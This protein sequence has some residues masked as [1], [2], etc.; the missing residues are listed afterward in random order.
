MIYNRSKET[1]TKIDR[2]SVTA[3]SKESFKLWILQ[4]YVTPNI[5][6]NLM[7]FLSFLRRDYLRHVGFEQRNSSV[8]IVYILLSFWFSPLGK[9]I[10]NFCKVFSLNK[11]FSSDFFVKICVF[12]S[13]NHRE[14]CIMLNLWPFFK[15]F[16][17]VVLL[18]S[19]LRRSCDCLT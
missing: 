1:L 3:F 19:L 11:T 2:V 17:L 9:R 6:F 4:N 15:N 14:S 10:S 16:Y 18:L 5:F 8:I 12:Q 7:L 13:A